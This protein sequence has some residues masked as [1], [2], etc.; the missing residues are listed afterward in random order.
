[1]PARKVAILAIVAFLAGMVVMLALTAPA[2][3]HTEQ[4]YPPPTLCGH[5]EIQF[6]VAMPN[7]TSVK[8][9]ERFQSGYGSGPHWHNYRV[10]RLA[11]NPPRWVWVHDHGRVCP[12]HQVL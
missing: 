8:H 1:M 9:L 3:G 12:A 6:W 11:Q 10:W 5:S 7:G 2:V 4:A